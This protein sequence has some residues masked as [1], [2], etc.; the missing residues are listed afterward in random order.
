MIKSA[1]WYWE[2]DFDRAG[3]ATLT[4]HRLAH[5][6]THTAMYGDLS[7]IQMA[8]LH[9]EG[10]EIKQATTPMTCFISGR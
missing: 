3:I 10:L 8:P 2:S 7:Q 4:Q 1:V 6:K 5:T 9:V